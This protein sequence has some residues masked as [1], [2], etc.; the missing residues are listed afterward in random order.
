[1]S[2]GVGLGRGGVDPQVYQRPFLGSLKL[3]HKFNKCLSYFSKSYWF[4]LVV[5]FLESAKSIIVMVRIYPKL[6]VSSQSPW[7][8]VVSRTKSS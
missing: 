5:N 6:S 2:S 1:M 8:K 3:K 4:Q 7:R